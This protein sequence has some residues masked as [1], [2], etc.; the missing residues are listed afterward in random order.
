VTVEVA[1]GVAMESM[2]SG[3][4]VAAVASSPMTPCETRRRGSDNER[5]RQEGYCKSPTHTATPMSQ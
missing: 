5:D 4:T 3:D 1:M 2:S